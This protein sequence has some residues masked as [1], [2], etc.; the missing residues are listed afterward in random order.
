[1][2]E[3]WQKEMDFNIQGKHLQYSNKKTSEWLQ[4]LTAN[5]VYTLG[6]WKIQTKALVLGQQQTNKEFKKSY[7]DCPECYVQLGFGNSTFR[8]GSQVIYW[9]ITDGYNPTNRINSKVYFNPLQ[10]KDRGELM[11]NWTHIADSQQF[12]LIYIPRH[13]RPLL[14][15][16]KSIWLPQQIPVA[17]GDSTTVVRVP[18]SL[19]YKF[20]KRESLNKADENNFGLQWT[21]QKGDA[22]INLNYFEGLSGFPIIYP[23]VTGNIIELDPVRVVEVTRDLDIAFFD[24]KVR[25]FGSSLLWNFESFIFKW[26]GVSTESLGDDARLPGKQFEQVG[27]LEK[28]WGLGQTGLLTGLLQMSSVSSQQSPDTRAL[29]ALGFFEQTA[30]LGLRYSWSEKW[31]LT[32]FSAQQLKNKSTLSQ[33]DLVYDLNENFQILAQSVLIDGPST[34]LMGLWRQN[35]FYSIGAKILF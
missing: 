5:G 16:E 8:M 2:A 15:D 19:N 34:T 18:D 25:S 13:Q 35:D 33:I 9:G 7:I 6:S 11:M 23:S 21:L 17:P 28:S 10:T 12:Q 31:T 32:G 1:M 14:P 24:Y 29:S 26:S 3:A 22:E 30:M 4:E 27:G 20:G